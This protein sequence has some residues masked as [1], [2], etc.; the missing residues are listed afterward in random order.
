[1]IRWS[2]ILIC[3]N[4]FLACDNSPHAPFPYT[5]PCGGAPCCDTDGCYMFFE[6]ALYH[7]DNVR[8][9]LLQNP[10]SYVAALPW[11]SDSLVLF[12]NLTNLIIADVAL[13][14]IPRGVYRIRRLWSL[15]LFDL[16]RPESISPGIAALDSLERLAVSGT[17][18]DTL[19]FEIWSLKR[20]AF[21]GLYINELSGCPL[22]SAN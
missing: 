2:C 4:I 13:D 6:T 21:L 15:G 11:F 16:R 10:G 12:P 1:M 9:L 5:G 22:R 14:T 18:L 7:K 17:R 20:L 3:A 8:T 19:P